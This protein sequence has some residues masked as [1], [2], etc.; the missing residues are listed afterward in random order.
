MIAAGFA[1]KILRLCGAA[2]LAIALFLPWL[3]A[4]EPDQPDQQTEQKKEQPV[5]GG[6]GP[7]YVPPQ[8]GGRA[9]RGGRAWPPVR[10]ASGATLRA[11][12]QENLKDAVQLASLSELLKKEIEQSSS[13]VLSAGAVKKTDEIEKLVKRIRT[14]MVRN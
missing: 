4:Q 13:F 2:A 12:R 10:G 14:R 11:E 9:G 3:P 6:S 7:R 1:M 5:N 8:I